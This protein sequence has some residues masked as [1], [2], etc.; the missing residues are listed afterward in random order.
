M[1]FIC[2]HKAS[3]CVPYRPLIA[4]DNRICHQWIIDKHF[5]SEPSMMRA[6]GCYVLND[7]TLTGRGHIFVDDKL[8]T[9]DD[10]MPRYWRNMIENNLIDL[11]REHQL[12]DREIDHTCVV[13][14]G[15]GVS[16]YGHVLLEMILRLR[17]FRELGLQDYKVLISD[18]APSWVSELIRAS[19]E[20][21]SDQI[22][23]YSPNVE[24]LRLRTAIIPTQL[25]STEDFHPATKSLVFALS[26][27]T[28]QVE[29]S[30]QPQRIV[31]SRDRFTNEK[32][33]QRALE[34]APELWQFLV[35]ER[36]FAIVRPE[37]L[38]WSQQIQ[39]FKGARV[40]VGEYG[41]AL[42]NA[43]FSGPGTILASVGFLNF[44]QSAIGTLFGHRQSYFTAVDEAN[45]A[46][47]LSRFKKWI[48]LLL[49]DA[50]S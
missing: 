25:H 13:F 41:S 8:V 5:R 29:T 23:V 32:S 46:A 43:I 19:M 50:E 34:N 35:D 7:V 47:D 31:I 24:K 20:L 48:D 18:L 17:L 42:H 38:S 11:A 2:L 16:V 10:L 37:E 6:L 15:H 4:A 45:Q 21:R 40:V 36:G 12:P 1:A 9:T 49:I 39:L 44:T 28:R 26:D 22:E 30:T 27:Y 14:M 3:I 33:I